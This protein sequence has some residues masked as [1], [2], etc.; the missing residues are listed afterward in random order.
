MENNTAVEKNEDSRVYEVGYL[1]SPEIAEE[2]VMSHVVAIKDIIASFGGVLIS[3][4]YP[5]PIELAYDMEKV[6]S[7]KKEIYSRAYFGWVKFD[8][9]PS[10]MD[11]LKAKLEL[12]PMIIRFL[13]IKT[14][15][16]NTMSSKKTFSARKKFTAKRDD[17]PQVEINKEEIDA[18]IDALVV[19]E[20][21]VKAPPLQ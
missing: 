16:E 4:E 17:E 9:D 11:S 19:G 10:T 1:L 6:I 20:E 21:E 13:L 18:Q 5:K 7:N 12:D 3:D 14:V 2:S 8:G 15:R